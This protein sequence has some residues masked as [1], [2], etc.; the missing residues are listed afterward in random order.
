MLNAKCTICSASKPFWAIRS[1]YKPVFHRYLSIGCAYSAHRRRE[2]E[3]WRFSCRRQWQ[4]QRQTIALSLAH[5]RGVIICLSYVF[6]VACCVQHNNNIEW[7]GR[8]AETS[9][10]C[11]HINTWAQQLISDKTFSPC[12]HNYCIQI[13]NSWIINHFAW[14]KQ[15]L[16][17][18]SLLYKNQCH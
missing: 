16:I 2:L 12:T 14:C 17:I 3:I 6:N 9:R 13:M 11:W 18:V 7:A 1:P 5:A 4:R 15:C 8:L 10:H